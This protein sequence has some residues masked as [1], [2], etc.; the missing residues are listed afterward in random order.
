MLKEFLKNPRALFYAVSVHV[1]LL[2]LLVMS[3]KWNIKPAPLQGSGEIVQAVV[4]DEGKLQA[5]KER[6][7]QDAQRRRDAEEAARRAEEQQ[8]QAALDKQRAEEQ[9]KR[10]AQAAALKKKQQAAEQQRQAKLKA[11]K[12]AGDRKLAEQQ[13]QRKQEEQ[14][15]K[16]AEAQRQADEQRKADEARRQRE[17][18]EMMRQQMAQEEQDRLAQAKAEQRQRELASKMSQYALQLKNI[19]ERNWIRPATARTGL[20]CTL[21]VRLIPGGE[22]T[23]ARVTKSSGDPNFDRSAETAVLKSSPLPMPPDSS[24]REFDFVFNPE[25]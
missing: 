22:V 5:E 1:V 20:I 4:I 10:E 16:A 18:L 2:L 9:R 19:V 8:R 23:D 15:R 12:E 14:R 3:L 7:R 11:E 21:H 6:K 17:N 13:A 24:L 25:G